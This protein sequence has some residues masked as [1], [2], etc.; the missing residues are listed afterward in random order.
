MI[1]RL[2]RELLGENKTQE[3]A[4]EALQKD[5]NQKK[6]NLQ[7]L[8]A[9]TFVVCRRDISSKHRNCERAGRINSKIKK[10]RSH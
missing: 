3:V 4:A 6:K 2:M 1:A 7:D 10:P 9:E 5:R 8:K